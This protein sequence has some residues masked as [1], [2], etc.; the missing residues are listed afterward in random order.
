MLFKPHQPMDLVLVAKAIEDIVSML[1]NPP[2]QIAGHADI[3]RAVGPVGQQVNAG[4]FHGPVN[5]MDCMAR[6]TWVWI[7][8][9]LRD[10]Q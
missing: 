4:L 10:S 6:V 5:L 7:A 1:P 2:D 8:T 9:S 3:E